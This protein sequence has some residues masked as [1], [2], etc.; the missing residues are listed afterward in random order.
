MSSK[1]Y[2]LDRDILSASAS[3]PCTGLTPWGTPLIEPNRALHAGL[4]AAGI[5]HTY[6]EFPGGHE[7]PYWEAHLAA[8]LRFF[9][10][11]L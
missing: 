3:A 7:W 8:T 2:P 1:R 5:A 9:A 4:I 10:R 6:E 11:Q